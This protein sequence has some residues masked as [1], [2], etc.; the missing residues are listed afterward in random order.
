MSTIRF[1]LLAM[2]APT[3]VAQA[4]SDPVIESRTHYRAAVQAYEARD[5]PA[6]LEHARRAQALRPTHGG[7]TYALASALALAGDTAAALA[8]LRHYAALGYA[9]DLAAD[10]D[11]AAVRGS[12]AYDELGRR[13]RRNAEPLVASR[14][15]F[16]IRERDL[17][18]EGIAYDPGDDAFYLGSV[19]QAKILRVTRAGI[20]SEFVAQVA[21]RW[22]P[23]GLRVDRKRKALWVAA[24]A[25]PQTAG[26]VLAD[27][28][29][30]AILRYD[31]RSGRLV[32]RYDAPADGTPRLIGDLIVTRG[33]DVYGSDSRAPVLYRVPG[34]GD[35][36][37]RFVESPLLLSA[38]GLA[39]SADERVLYVADYSRGILRVDVPTRRVSP[40]QASDGVLALGIDG[41]YIHEGKLIGIQN[42]VAPHRVTRFTLSPDGDRLLRAELLERA[43]PR[44]QAFTLHFSE[45]DAMWSPHNWLQRRHLRPFCLEC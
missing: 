24:A 9:A 19:H 32:A 20:V 39:L 45:L 42:G 31:L 40:V 38:Q 29:R 18:T 27:S 13:L 35:T 12:K 1:L 8:T 14:V 4:Q 2:L 21:G 44:R 43:H 3:A 28:G 15:A 22:A 30:S 25:L 36:L 33:G 17:L 7:M 16:E 11:F 23:M 10:P 34:G 6:F 5:V 41:L 37:E 26:Y